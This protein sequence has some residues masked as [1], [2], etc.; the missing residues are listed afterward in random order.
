MTELFL[1]ALVYARNVTKRPASKDEAKAKRFTGEMKTES[2]VK[3][4]R[5][6]L[7]VM[8]PKKTEAI[9]APK[10]A[11]EEIPIIPGS[12]RGFLKKSWKTAPLPPSKMPV[13]KTRRERGSLSFQ[14]I[15]FSNLLPKPK[16][17]AG[18]T[19]SAP[20]KRESAK[21]KIRIAMERVMTAAFLAPL[22][23]IIFI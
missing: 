19:F 17:A 6:R 22:E 12:A 16:K 4:G 21:L 14:R 5:F 1:P 9:T 23:I 2:F 20:I 15:M 10:V 13:I 18:L 8:V 7:A 3:R 11:P